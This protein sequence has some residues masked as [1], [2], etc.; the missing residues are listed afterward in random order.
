MS[1]TATRSV[2]TACTAKRARPS[3]PPCERWSVVL[4]DGRTVRADA[5]TASEARAIAKAK[6]GLDRLPPGT[7]VYHLKQLRERKRNALT[8][9]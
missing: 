1:I 4:P 2:L 9:I 6:L 3:A 7:T 8:L 5:N